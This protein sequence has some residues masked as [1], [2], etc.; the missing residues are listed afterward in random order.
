MQD[1]VFLYP[2]TPDLDPEK[3]TKNDMPAPG[4]LS[5]DLRVRV[6]IVRSGVG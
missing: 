3:L 5:G 4:F 6:G 1:M 2:A